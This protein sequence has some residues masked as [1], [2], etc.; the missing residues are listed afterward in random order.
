MYQTAIGRHGD[1]TCTAESGAIRN[2]ARYHCAIGP[3]QFRGESQSELASLFIS[4]SRFFSVKGHDSL[5][6]L[7]VVLSTKGK[8]KIQKV[9]KSPVTS[10]S[11][12]PYLDTFK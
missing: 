6:N 10:K 1:R 2:R 11:S 4:F 8:S 12:I 5:F 9:S 3:A 7:L